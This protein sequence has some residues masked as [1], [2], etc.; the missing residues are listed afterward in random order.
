MQ[1]INEATA[2]LRK[3]IKEHKDA[4]KELEAEIKLIEKDFGVTE[5]PLRQIIKKYPRLKALKP[6]TDEQCDELIEKYGEKRVIDMTERMNN[7]RDINKKVY[8]YSTI[9]NWLETVDTKAVPTGRVIKDKDW[10]ETRDT[11]RK[12]DGNNPEYKKGWLLD[13][14]KEN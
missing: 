8:Y 1:L 6:P 2:G 14:T 9:K 3:Q 12:H 10:E 13:N 5:H 7:W 4:I 11:I